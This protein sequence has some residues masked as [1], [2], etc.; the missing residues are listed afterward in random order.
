[1]KGL[2]KQSHIKSDSI[3]YFM[4]GLITYV[5]KLMTGCLSDTCGHIFSMRLKVVF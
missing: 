2:N 1:M 3:K 5:T 4:S